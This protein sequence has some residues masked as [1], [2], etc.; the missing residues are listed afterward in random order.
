[1]YVIGLYIGQAE[2]NSA[3]GE[4]ETRDLLIASPAMQPLHHRTTK[5]EVEDEDLR[6]KTVRSVARELIY[7][8]SA[9]YG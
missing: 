4:N 9:G 1:M 5:T 2:L 8:L 6:T 3:E 7:Q